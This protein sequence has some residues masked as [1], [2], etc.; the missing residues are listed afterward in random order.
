MCVPA[1][2]SGGL[3]P[4]FLI[5]INWFKARGW[6]VIV[7]EGE[8]VVFEVPGDRLPADLAPPPDLVEIA[9]ALREAVAPV[10]AVPHFDL[11]AYLVARLK[12]E[13]EDTLAR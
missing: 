9:P 4:T 1:G 12:S 6:A 13:P 11:D 10:T 5:V 8:R 2:S 3:S 7:R